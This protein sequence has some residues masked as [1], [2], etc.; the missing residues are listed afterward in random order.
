MPEIWAYL[1]NPD[2]MTVRWLILCS[3]NAAHVSEPIFRRLPAPHREGRLVR[4]L[5]ALGGARLP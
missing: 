2:L 4:P 3:V 1:L 5:L